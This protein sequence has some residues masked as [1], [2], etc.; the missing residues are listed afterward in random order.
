VIKAITFD[1]WQ[2]LILDSP[3]GLQRA[4]EARIQGVRE[5][6]AS[7][8][9]GVGLAEMEQA[10]EESGKRL[11]EIWKGPTDVSLMEQVGIFLGSL[12]HRYFPSLG[13]EALAM[14]ERA[15]ASPI[16]GAMPALNEGAVETLEWLKGKNYKIG[17]ISNTGRTPGYMLRIVL[18]R[19]GILEYFDALTFS[20]EMRLRKPDP[21]VFHSTLERLS[22]APRNAIHVGDDLKADVVGAKGAG[23]RAIHLRRTEQPFSDV[24]PDRTIGTLLEF[25]EVLEGLGWP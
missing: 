2:T 5:I 3:E 11:Q 21:R 10:Y 18:E 19:L 14:L 17:L 16:L 4:R 6:L 7:W 13:S 22:A 23:M 15:Y 20:D 12:D 25:S 9:I 24:A 1:L 8:G